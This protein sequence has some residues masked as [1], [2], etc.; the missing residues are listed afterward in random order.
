MVIASIF[1]LA[2]GVVFSTGVV[3]VIGYAVARS[4]EKMNE[5]REL[6]I[7]DPHLPWWAKWRFWFWSAAILFLLYC[8]I[9]LLVP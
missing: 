2:I 1:E 7:P 4:T 9:N 3:I 6:N 8:F 5:R